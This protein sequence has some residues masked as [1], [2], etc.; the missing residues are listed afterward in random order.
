MFAASQD[1]TLHDSTFEPCIIRNR[2][3]R[4]EPAGTPFDFDQDKPALRKA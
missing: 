1:C 3:K 2:E 4:K